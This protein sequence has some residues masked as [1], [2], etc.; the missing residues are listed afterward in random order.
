MMQIL[1]R[2]WCHPFYWHSVY[3]NSTV[4]SIVEWPSQV[5]KKQFNLQLGTN[6]LY[7]YLHTNKAV[8]EAG[9]NGAMYV[10]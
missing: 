4:Q 9:E 3:T 10:P 2:I 7:I 6:T 8:K 5:D 1:P